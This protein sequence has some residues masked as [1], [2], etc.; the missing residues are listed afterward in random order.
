M[1][2][3]SASVLVVID[4][5][6]LRDTCVDALA[7]LPGLTV[8]AVRDGTQALQ[9]LDAQP[10]ALVLVEQAMPAVN[11]RG[12]L[13]GLQAMHPETSF[14]AYVDAGL[15]PEE[16]AAYIHAGAAHVLSKPVTPER[17]RTRVAEI[18]NVEA[19]RRDHADRFRHHLH[20]AHLALEGRQLVAASEHARKALSYEGTRP[21]PFN[22][23][24]VVAQLS[25]DLAGAQRL[26]RVA[27]A[28]DPQFAPARDNLR[29]ISGFPKKVS[30]FTV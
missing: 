16:A 24:G 10:F 22:V 18:L 12:L 6:D 8:E 21:E 29:A 9:R 4:Q 26:Y 27:L 23:L 15:D 25:M 11:E 28:L 1:P 5:D 3:P 30:L 17:L 13:R 20:A 2:T 19:R 7:A 14:V